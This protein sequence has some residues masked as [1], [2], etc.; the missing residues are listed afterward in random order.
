VVVV[1]FNAGDHVP[2][3]PFVDVVGKAPKE[4]PAHTGPT[5]V[6]VGVMIGFTVMVMV[7]VFA[8]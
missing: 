1:L 6:N 3:I 8:H 5:A 2:L 4:V 7:V